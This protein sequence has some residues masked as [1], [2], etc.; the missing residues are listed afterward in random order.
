MLTTYY[1]TGND[2]TLRSVDEKGTKGMRIVSL[3]H[4]PG[5]AQAGEEGGACA[6]SL[7]LLAMCHVCTVRATACTTTGGPA[8][9]ADAAANGEAQTRTQVAGDCSAHCGHTASGLPLT[10]QLSDVI[11]CSATRRDMGSTRA[12]LNGRVAVTPHQAAS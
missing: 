8:L 1:A 11:R 7:E 4:A 3:S 12:R 5:V 2:P 6:S 9:E 10:V